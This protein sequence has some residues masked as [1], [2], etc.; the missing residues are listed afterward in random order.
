[1]PSS[2]S[3]HQLLDPLPPPAAKAAMERYLSLPA[4]PLSTGDGAAA[5]AL[6]LRPTMI[7]GELCYRLQVFPF[8]PIDCCCQH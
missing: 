4:S 8:R 5:K 6:E 2:P 7:S 3:L 1:M